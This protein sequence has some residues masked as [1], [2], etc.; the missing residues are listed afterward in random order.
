MARICALGT[1]AHLKSYL[2]PIGTVHP[3]P[4]NDTLYGPVDSNDRSIQQ[5]AKEMKAEGHPMRAANCSLT[6]YFNIIQVLAKLLAFASCD[7]SRKII[8]KYVD[9]NL[10][11]LS[12][13]R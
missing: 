11:D 4:K 3:S 12:Q 10:L 13:A 6:L 7:F 9:L 5:M 8:N 1:V 2:L